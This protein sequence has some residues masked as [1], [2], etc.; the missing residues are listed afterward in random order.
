MA[1]IL[2]KLPGLTKGLPGGELLPDDIGLFHRPWPQAVAVADD[3]RP[4]LLRHRNDGLL[5]IALGLRPH[6]R[7]PARESASGGRHDR[8]RHRRQE[9]GRSDP[10]DL[11]SDAGAALRD[12][13]GLLRQLRRPVLRLLLRPEGR[14]SH[15]ARRRLHRRLPAAARRRCSTPS[16]NSR[17]RSPR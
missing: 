4:R 5:R 15:R 12:L 11:P 13:D 9:D 1:M 17:K 16:S 14:R 10:R 3:L 7:H 2:E 6:G 8:R